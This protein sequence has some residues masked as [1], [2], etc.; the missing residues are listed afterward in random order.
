MRKDYYSPL[1]VFH[2]QDRLQQMKQGKVPY[3]I[4]VQ[5]VPTNRCNHNCE[6]CAY[7]NS[8]YSSNERFND[9]DQIPIDKLMEIVDSCA[10]MGVRAIELTGGGEPTI[11][12]QFPDLCEYIAAN[13]ID[14]GVVT[15]GSLSNDRLFHAL[16]GAKWVRFS[17]DAGN[18]WTYAQERRVKPDTYARVRRNIQDLTATKA[19]DKRSDPIVGMGF[20]VTQ[21][22]YNE[23]VDAV[24]AAQDDGADNIRISAYFQDGGAEYFKLFLPEILEQ[25]TD[26]RKLETDEFAV[27]DLFS[28][29]LLDLGQGRPDYETCY[30]QQLCTYVGADQNFYRCC[31]LAYNGRGLLGS[32]KDRTLSQLWEDSKSDMQNFDARGC[33][34]CMFNSKNRTI[35]YAANPQPDHVNFI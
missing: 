7:R 19:I 15:N 9:A 23:I 8:G 26:A 21:H 33:E 27:F 29:R 24:V 18:H 13:G 14:Y 11:H 28:D 1:K 32:L 3:P 20:V 34:R 6:F 12:P 25:C 31:V 5:I 22:N 4:H 2:H 35:A 30:Y 16:L 17:V 10:E